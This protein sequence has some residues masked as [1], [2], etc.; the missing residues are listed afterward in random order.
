MPAAQTKTKTATIS[1]SVA[2]AIQCV[3]GQMLDG[4]TLSDYQNLQITRASSLRHAETGSVC[5]ANK[6]KALS[7]LPKVSGVVCLISA[8][9]AND[10]PA[11]PIYIIV[12]H[13]KNRFADLL[14][15]MYPPV[16]STGQIHSMVDISPEASIGKNVQIDSFVHIGRGVVI[17]DNCIINAGVVI[18]DDVVIGHDTV[19]MANTTIMNAS[20]G[21]HVVVAAGV[22]IGASGF[23]L[24]DDGRNHLVTH[25]GR[26]SIGDYCYIGPKSS[27]DR[28]MLDDTV[29]GAHVMMDSHCNLAHNVKVGDGS[30]IC[31]RTGLAGS[32]EIGCRNILGPAVR[33]ADHVT[34]GDDNVFV[35]LTGVTK[36]VGNNQVMGGFPA[37]PVS[38]FRYQVAALRRLVR[39]IKQKAKERS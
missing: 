4:A 37:V 26:V 30:I 27:I 15:V 20:L 18:T 28:G 5:F 13:P 24:T 12:D 36:Q 22:V 34:I 11:G 16:V 39:D 32:V 1:L 25:I 9:V 6:A 2:D 23:G 38:D 3:S 10:A 17:G 8:D 14:A 29:V 35:S 31:S 33:V 19:V 7:Q 21:D